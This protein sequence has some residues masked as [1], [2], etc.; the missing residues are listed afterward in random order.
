MKQYLLLLPVAVMLASCAT[1]N[2]G[3]VSTDS[4]IGT[5]QGTLT[6]GSSAGLV[7]QI[8]QINAAG[9]YSGT[10]TAIGK[11]KTSSAPVSGNV[12]LGTLNSAFDSLPFT[13]KGKFTENR[14][15][16]GS[17]STSGGITVY[18]TIALDKR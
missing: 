10:L 18:P 4:V 12:N 13:C 1:N 11:E 6:L 3:P 8:T 9:D 17:C 14:Q 7:G 15:Y 5:W 16:R 2:A